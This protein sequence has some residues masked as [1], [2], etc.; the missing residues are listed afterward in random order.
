MDKPGPDLPSGDLISDEMKERFKNRFLSAL[1][2][3][4]LRSNFSHIGVDSISKLLIDVFDEED[5]G[6]PEA[7][8]AACLLAIQRPRDWPNRIARYI[9]FLSGS[10]KKRL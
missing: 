4:I 10:K 8:G 2:G 3:F 5:L 9:K 1:P 7:L 6:T